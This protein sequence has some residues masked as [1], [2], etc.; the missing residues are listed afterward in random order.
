MGTTN[1][2]EPYDEAKYKVGNFVFNSPTDAI[3]EQIRERNRTT[4]GAEITVEREFN[5]FYY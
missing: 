4:G 5:E 1:G 3:A 2:T